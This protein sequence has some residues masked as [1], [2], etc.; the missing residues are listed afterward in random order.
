MG[1]LCSGDGKA[2][3]G[4]P[5][6]PAGG[7]GFDIGKNGT[8]LV[9]RK[10]GQHVGRFWEAML[11]Q[12]EHDEK[13]ASLYAARIIGRWPSGAPLVRHPLEDVEH[14][15]TYD[16]AFDFD[17][18]DR[19]GSRCP[20]GAHIR[21]ANPRNMLPPDPQA[22]MKAVQRHRLL[23]RGRPYGPPVAA[24]SPEGRAKDDGVDRGLVFLVLNASIRR[25]FEFVQQTWLNNP[26]FAGLYHERDPL[27]ATAKDD[28]DPRADLT[29]QG[30]PVRGKLAGLPRFVTNR[31][32]GYFF[33]P[34]KKA[35]AWL[36]ARKR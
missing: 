32:G 22:S 1:A 7:D 11:T 5:P 27:V 34:G 16:P 31:G 18:L 26:K 4:V 19:D 30:T 6:S 9:Y 23:R 12:A 20:F 25:Q 17:K 15:E 3:A 2:S 33:L 28:D 8:Y 36:A 35:I 24:H 29:M 14:G 10:L 21:R 13:R